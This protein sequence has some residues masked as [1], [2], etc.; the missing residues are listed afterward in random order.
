MTVD[1]MFRRL[2]ARGYFEI[3]AGEQ[4]DAR[5]TSTEGT[6]W[7]TY[8]HAVVIAW[9]PTGQGGPRGPH[10]F[11]P[12]C[13]RSFVASTLDE[14]LRQALDATAPPLHPLD[15]LVAH[16]TVEREGQA[17]LRFMGVAV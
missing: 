5:W 12:F 1:Q 3:T 2:A 14:A 13:S 9:A 7:T 11:N 16:R 8:K 15:D 4:V 17:L 10:R 6:Q